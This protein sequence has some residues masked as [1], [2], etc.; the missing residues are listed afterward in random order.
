MYKWPTTKVDI[1]ICSYIKF[2]DG[3]SEQFL[4]NS[5]SFLLENLSP[6]TKYVLHLSAFI[7]EIEGNG[8]PFL[9]CGTDCW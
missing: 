6:D 9:S 7:G 3:S 1:E 2:I 5:T 8:S 4:T